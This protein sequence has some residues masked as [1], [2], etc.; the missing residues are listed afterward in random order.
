[1]K[2]RPYAECHAEYEKST[3]GY[4]QWKDIKGQFAPLNIAVIELLPPIVIG[5]VWLLIWGSIGIVRWVLRGFGIQFKQK[6]DEAETSEPVPVMERLSAIGHWFIA[7]RNILALSVGI[8]ALAVSYY[9]FLVS[10]PASNRERLQF[11]K[12][13]AEAARVERDKKEEDAKQAIEDRKMSF[14]TCETDADTTY[15][16]YVKLNGKEVPGKLGTYSAPTFI[17][18]AADKRKADALAEC[19]RQ[20]DK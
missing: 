13:R 6:A 12:D 18:T 9:Y 14:A 10:L 2:A 16:N 11:E 8:V 20:F 3:G 15:W 17:W 19:H 1:M 4:S 7:P 5:L